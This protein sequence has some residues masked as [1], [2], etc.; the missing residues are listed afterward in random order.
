[1]EYKKLNLS[2]TKSQAGNISSRLILPISWIRELGKNENR[3]EVHVYKVN[4]L[5]IVSPERQ[6]SL[7]DELIKS[8][9]TNQIKKLFKENGW[10]STVQIDNIF[11]KII[12]NFYFL[13]KNNEEYIFQYLFKFLKKTYLELM[14]FLP[15]DLDYYNEDMGKKLDSYNE[16]IQISGKDRYPVSYYLDTYNYDS[17]LE[18]NCRD[19]KIEMETLFDSEEQ[20][21]REVIYLF[22]KELQEELKF[23]NLEEFKIAVGINKAPVVKVEVKDKQTKELLESFENLSIEQKEKMLATLKRMK[24]KEEKEK[25]KLAEQKKKEEEIEE[26]RLFN[27]D[28]EE[29]NS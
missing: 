12:D 15:Y 3:R 22:K 21:T 10:I 1:M 27:T 13:N 23:N 6:T 25:K 20:E 5:I 17:Y 26:E 2:F 16:I 24:K 14:K 29:T 8:E 18:I 28:L 19:S 7:P 4:D 11:K 9:I